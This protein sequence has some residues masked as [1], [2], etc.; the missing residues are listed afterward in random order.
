MEH[1]SKSRTNHKR[2]VQI[3]ASDISASHTDYLDD[4]MLSVLLLDNKIP[5]TDETDSEEGE[6]LND[7][8]N[9]CYSL[10]ERDKPIK[11]IKGKGRDKLF[12][13][14]RAVPIDHHCQ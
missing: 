7:W 4:V 2:R 10:R 3:L 1:I 6:D 5:F 12:T 13:G 8:Q 14:S 9:L 11:Y